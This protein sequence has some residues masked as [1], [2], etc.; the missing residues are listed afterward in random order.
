MGVKEVET[1][2][3]DAMVGGTS[4]DINPPVEA[5]F[6]KIVGLGIYYI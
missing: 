5:C 4:A 2:P 1:R 3:T 6:V